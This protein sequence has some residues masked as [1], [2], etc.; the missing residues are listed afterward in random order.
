MGEESCSLES[1][2]LISLI[3]LTEPVTSYNILSH[4]TALLV[5]TQGLLWLR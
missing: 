3:K 5:P 2:T 1:F 4:P